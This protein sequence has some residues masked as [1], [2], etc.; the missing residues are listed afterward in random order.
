MHTSTTQTYDIEDFIPGSEAARIAGYT[1]DYIAKLARDGKVLGKRVGK[2]WHVSIA[3]LNA[4]K[5]QSEREKR[6]RNEQIRQERLRE[7]AATAVSAAPFAIKTPIASPFVIP[8]RARMHRRRRALMQTAVIVFV[9]LATGIGSYGVY[10]GDMSALVG[11]VE[12]AL[13]GAV[14]GQGEVPAATQE[15]VA[16]TVSPDASLF[17]DHATEMPTTII[18]PDSVLTAEH[19][20]VIRDSLSDDVT[21]LPDPEQSDTGI[22]I[23]HFKDADGEPYRFLTLPDLN[24]ES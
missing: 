9:G 8:V 24:L 2:A 19:A 6:E 5:E 23:P 18:A 1:S 7:Q 3:S 21:I 20:Q 17:S 10:T 15:S 14:L 22:I 4:F 12:V 16:Q 11:R 13:Q